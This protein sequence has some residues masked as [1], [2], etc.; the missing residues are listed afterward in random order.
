MAPDFGEEAYY[1]RF[2]YKI[3]KILTKLT[4]A[5]INFIYRICGNNSTGTKLYNS[6]INFSP[7]YYRRYIWEIFFLISRILNVRIYCETMLKYE[8]LYT[9]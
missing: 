4:F 8:S 5:Y 6:L 7:D 3:E 2:I 9:K 1:E